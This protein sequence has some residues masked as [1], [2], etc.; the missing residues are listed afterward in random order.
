M[1]ILIYMLI[2]SG[3]IEKEFDSL[4]DVVN[5]IEGIGQDYFEYVDLHEDEA[6]ICGYQCI[7]EYCK[8]W[9]NL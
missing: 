7:Y 6:V 9:S 1:F 2:D 3:E 5:F 8:I 4:E